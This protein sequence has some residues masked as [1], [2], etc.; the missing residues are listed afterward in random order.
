MDR[1]APRPPGGGTGAGAVDALGAAAAA[2][3]AAG[4]LHNAPFPYA[5]PQH[6][7]LD[8]VSMKAAIDFEEDQRMTLSRH[9]LLGCRCVLLL[10]SWS[11]FRDVSDERKEG[12]D[13]LF[14]DLPICCICGEFGTS[15]TH[16]R[17]LK[18]HS[19]H[20]ERCPDAWTPSETATYILSLMINKEVQFPGSWPGAQVSHTTLRVS[21]RNRAFK[22]GPL[23]PTTVR[24]VASLP[25]AALSLLLVYPRLV[26]IN[27]PPIFSPVGED[28]LASCASCTITYLS[29]NLHKSA[30]CN[31]SQ[32]ILWGAEDVQRDTCPDLRLL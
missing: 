26:R 31:P 28:A 11:G 3:A 23:G 14:S 25:L 6:Y 21:L 24:P 18:L 12:S 15:C 17:S 30:R 19:P 20:D 27:Q 29:S 10:D 13:V 9:S 7:E 16:S 1:L 4:G 32:L 5:L 8:Q 2:A 22:C